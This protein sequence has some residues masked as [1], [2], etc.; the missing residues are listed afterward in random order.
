MNMI[1]N[2]K[3]PL[4]ASANRTDV[5]HRDQSL[6]MLTNKPHSGWTCPKAILS[7]HLLLVSQFGGGQ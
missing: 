1:S 6:L 2:P 7:L 3:E 4:G 5:N